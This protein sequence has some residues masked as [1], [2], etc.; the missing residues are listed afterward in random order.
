MGFNSV[1]KGL[2]SI[3]TETK[4]TDCESKNRHQW[5]IPGAP[6]TIGRN[7]FVCCV[8]SN[9][10]Q[11]PVWEDQLRPKQIARRKQ[12]LETAIAIVL[13]KITETRQAMYLERNTAAR[14]HNQRYRGNQ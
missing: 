1:F 5:S 11:V 2:M 3:Y 8:F 7:C 6:E 9:G 4:G 13:A 14:S 10:Q 12:I